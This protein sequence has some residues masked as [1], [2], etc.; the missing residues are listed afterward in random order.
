MK[1]IEKKDNFERTYIVNYDKKELKRLLN[2]LVKKTSYKVDGKFNAPRNASFKDNVFTSGASLPNGDPMYENIKSIYRY[3]SNGPYS[4][5]YDSIAVEGTQVIPPELAFII[6]R[7]LSD[8]PDSIYEFLNYGTHDELVPI[9]EKITAANKTVDGIDNFD[10]DK[11]I[12]ELNKLK[13]LCEKR[14]LKLYFDTELL[15]HYYSQACDLI[16]LQL[17]SEKTVLSEQNSISISKKLKRTN[18]K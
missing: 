12:N 18:N 2:E 11:K 15:K 6:E 3:T 5:R 16:N 1:F 10:F 7:I 8:E 17:I 9:D 13:N 4:Y 14:K